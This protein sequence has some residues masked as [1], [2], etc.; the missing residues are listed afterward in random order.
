[1]FFS[2]RI[3]FPPDYKRKLP[4]LNILILRELVS[5]KLKI[6]Q[7]NCA[8]IK[9]RG[10]NYN[11]ATYFIVVLVVEEQCLFKSTTAIYR[12]MYSL[13]KKS[14]KTRLPT[15]LSA[16]GKDSLAKPYRRYRIGYL[17]ISKRLSL[18]AICFLDIIAK[19]KD[20]SHTSRT[21]STPKENTKKRC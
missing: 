12:G 18:K 3:I 2:C 13:K 6:T 10:A 8:R 16:S 4:Q 14:V 19:H 17:C 5:L 9:S 20:I 11:L 21:Y 1:M 15:S 7:S